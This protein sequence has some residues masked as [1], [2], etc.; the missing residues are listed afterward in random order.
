MLKDHCPNCGHRFGFWGAPFTLP[1]RGSNRR[2]PDY[3]CPACGN[4]LSRIEA[5]LESL[6]K[7]V[8]LLALL[9][10]SAGML[11]HLLEVPVKPSRDWLLVLYGVA[12]VGI[13]VN[14]VF[15]IVRQHFVL[16]EPPG[17]DTVDRQD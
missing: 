7:W 10:A 4:H 2:H 14:L 17:A 1:P 13:A 8:G 6:A 15:S 16:D 11:W 9:A 5:P 12:V 3:R